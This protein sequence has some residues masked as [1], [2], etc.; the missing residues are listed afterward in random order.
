LVIVNISY[1]IANNKT[2]F[3]SEIIKNSTH[4]KFELTYDITRSSI[5]I[6][7]PAYPPTVTT[8]KII[9]KE[10]K[11]PGSINPRRHTD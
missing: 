3:T 2:A 9:Q 6:A 1:A 10:G 4:G 5:K 7:S 8:C 11:S